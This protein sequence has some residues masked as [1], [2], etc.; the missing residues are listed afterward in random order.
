MDDDDDDDAMIMPSS[1]FTNIKKRSEA[2][3]EST[4]SNF[5]ATDPRITVK[6][7]EIS[8]T[9]NNDH[10]ISFD[11]T[12]SDSELTDAS[13]TC[14][15]TLERLKSS[16]INLEAS[17]SKTFKD[18][19][20][21]LKPAFDY[22]HTQST[23]TSN[24]KGNFSETVVNKSKDCHIVDSGVEMVRGFKGSSGSIQ[25]EEDVHLDEPVKKKKRTREQVEERKRELA[26]LKKAAKEKERQ[27]KLEEK[28]RQKEGRAAAM[29]EKKLQKEKDQLQKKVPDQPNSSMIA[30]F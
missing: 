16:I 2:E 6:P 27:E 26:M 15:K 3:N 12:D 18:N 10:K 23:T 4:T 14:R 9:T 11:L 28:K 29:Q 7:I 8:K 20:E 5:N 25:D 13:A 19:S 22:D 24:K 1:K 30:N 17:T 21:L